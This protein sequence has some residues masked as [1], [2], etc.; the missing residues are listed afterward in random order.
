[1]AALKA[2]KWG[3]LPAVWLVVEW[4]VVLVDLKVV[5][6]AVAKVVVLVGLKVESLAVKVNWLAV[7]L[8]DELVS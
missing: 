8:V 7:Y 2:G 6:M 3:V 4:V 5:R 1:M